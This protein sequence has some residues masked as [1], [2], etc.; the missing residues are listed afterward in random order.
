[1]TKTQLFILHH[2]GG[3]A[4]SFQFLKPYLKALDVVT[5]ELPGRGKRMGEEL[6][7]NYNDAVEDVYQQIKQKRDDRSFL[8]Y[9]HSM[10]ARIGLSVTQKLEQNNDAPVALI[11]TGNSDP[12]SYREEEDRHTMS[13]ERFIQALK[14]LGGVPNEVFENKDLF[15]FVEP[16][17]RADF[18]LIERERIV[19]GNPV[20][21]PVYAIMG[22]EESS[23]DRI[24]S[25]GKH[26]RASFKYELWPGNHFFIQEHPERLSNV[27]MANCGT[28][29]VY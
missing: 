11:V 9:G 24:D 17:I 18:E 12:E 28:P 5:L 23:S 20:N 21:T 13:K 29:L 6:L 3:N 4:Y 7:R 10:G 15:E 25:W 19:I 26:T 16:I 14:D 1:M 22:K 27:L 2:A 8:V